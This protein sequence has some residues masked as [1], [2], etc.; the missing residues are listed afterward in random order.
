VPERSRKKLQYSLRGVALGVAAL[1]VWLGFQANSAREQAAARRHLLE[2]DGQVLS[3]HEIAGEAPPVAP[4]ALRRLWGVDFFATVV[5]VNFHFGSLPDG[6]KYL[7]ALGALPGVT[8]INIEDAPI[9]EAHLAHLQR[10]DLECLRLV[11]VGIGDDALRHLAGMKR[12]NLLNLSGN[13]I[14]DDGLKHLARLKYLKYINVRQTNV[15]SAGADE[16]M[17]QIPSLEVV[18]GK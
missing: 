9:D 7:A 17:E 13:P 6:G 16:L 15:T 8:V 10:A 14:G 1:C 11:K 3:D 4:L 2:H 5:R 18:G 12:L